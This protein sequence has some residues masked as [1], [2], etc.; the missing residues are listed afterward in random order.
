MDH[1]T[2]VIPIRIAVALI[3][4]LLLLPAAAR[5]DAASSE[6]IVTNQLC[7]GLFY[8]PLEWESRDGEKHELTAL[9][10]TGDDE[11]RNGFMK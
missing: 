8:V 10:D 5:P 4:A 3:A 9:F 2:Q 1:E 7:G 6:T 11:S